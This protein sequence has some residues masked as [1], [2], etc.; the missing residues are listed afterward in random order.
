MSKRKAI[1]IA[2]PS[3]ND[4]ILEKGLRAQRH[5]GNI[6]YHNIIQATQ[7]EYS[8][9]KK[10]IVKDTIAHSV[11]N[12]VCGRFLTREAD[13]KTYYVASQE[14]VILKIKQAMRD[15][16]KRRMEK[17]PRPALVTAP[18]RKYHSGIARTS[19]AGGKQDKNRETNIDL[20]NKPLSLHHHSSLSKASVL[21]KDMMRVL[22][23]II[24]L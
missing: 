12:R 1:A 16:R 3:N 9:A 20:Q 6:H 22:D 15:A 13:G 4:V 10:R 11:F 24:N 19:L 2:K 8:V 21:D 17:T 23:I 5:P 18:Q 14:M 7:L